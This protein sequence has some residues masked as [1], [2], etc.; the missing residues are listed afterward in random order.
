MRQEVRRGLD[1]VQ[2]SMTAVEQ[3]Q[4]VL[5]SRLSALNEERLRMLDM[6]EQAQADH[7][8]TEQAVLQLHKR[9]AAVAAQLTQ[10]LAE[11]AD[12]RR[13]IAAFEAE[14]GTELESQLEA[15]EKDELRQLARQIQGLNARV[16]PSVSE[17]GQVLMPL[18]F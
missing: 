5:T 6:T 3:E 1:A 11:T 4:V 12:A 15:D 16:A 10:H 2:E 7:R 9:R 18:L 17:L 14:R 8:K 13:E